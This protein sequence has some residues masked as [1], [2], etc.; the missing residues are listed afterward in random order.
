[1]GVTLHF[2]GGVFVSTV[3]QTYLLSALNVWVT[4]DKLLFMALNAALWS[5]VSLEIFNAVS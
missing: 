3:P 2:R 4:D 1:L 5:Y